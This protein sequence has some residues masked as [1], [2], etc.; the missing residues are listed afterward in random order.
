MG[1]N[2]FRELGFILSAPIL[3]T[4]LTTI[5]YSLIGDVRRGG[6]VV[7]GL[8]FGAGLATATIPVF[9]SYVFVHLAL[10]AHVTLPVWLIAALT[11]AVA[12][13]YGAFVFGVFLALLTFLGLEETQAFTALDHPG[14]K[15]FVRLRVRQDG[16]AVDF[17]SLGLTDPLSPEARPELIDAGSFKLDL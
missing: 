14:F 9:A 1:L 3:I 2:H 7:F 6:L 4:V 10:S 5:I 16:S 12:V 13:F 15:H 17:W 11:F 8:S